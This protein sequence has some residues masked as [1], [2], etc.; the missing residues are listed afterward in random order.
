MIR[1]DPTPP[2]GERAVQVA[3]LV[4]VALSL[5]PFILTSATTG[6]EFTPVNLALRILRGEVMYRDFFEFV[7]PVS[8]WLLVGVFKIFGPSFIAARAFQ[9][10]LLLFAT[11]V[12]YRLMRRLEVSPLLAT[13]PGFLLLAALYPLLPIVSYHWIVVPFWLAALWLAVWAFGRERDA[14]WVGVGTLT[15]LAIACM[16]SDGLTLLIALGIMLGLGPLMGDTSWRRTTWRLGALGLGLGAVIV[17]ILAVLSLQGALLPAYKNIWVWTL[18]QYAIPGGVNDIRYLTDISVITNTTVGWVNLPFWYIRSLFFIGVLL[19]PPVVCLVALAWALDLAR[20]RL[21]EGRR[22]M[23]GEEAFGLVALFAIGCM[24]LS[25]RGRA[26]SIHV[27]LY[28][29]PAVLTATVFASRWARLVQGPGL[30]LIRFLPQLTLVAWLGAGLVVQGQRMVAEPEKWLRFS[31]PD[32]RHL[33]TPA[34]RYLREHGRS[35]DELVGFPYV[36]CIAFY[37][38][39]LASYWTQLMPP[40]YNY[41]TPA[42]YQVYW[43]GIL[44]RRPRFVVYQPHQQDKEVHDLYF[45]YPLPGYRHTV[46]LTTPLFDESL[47]AYI[48]EREDARSP[49]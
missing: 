41:I 37:T 34:I 20:L 1:P 12:C 48:Y 28:A 25:T 6:D 47:P 29:L 30:G 40:A 32:S 4:I 33:A 3:Y 8:R 13:L 14:A 31:S 35:G 18:T 17:P 21:H 9:G 23:P 22:W 46:T 45:I 11:W 10:L 15:G 7:P 24:V 38:W 16:Q 43:A 49:L 19:L 27:G 2:A 44:A 39:P 42:E 26:D 5:V 36:D